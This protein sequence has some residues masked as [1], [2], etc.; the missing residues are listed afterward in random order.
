MCAPCQC[1]AS[2]CSRAIYCVLCNETVCCMHHKCNSSAMHN[3]SPM[4]LWLSSSNY[5][6]DLLCRSSCSVDLTSPMLLWLS[7]SNYN[8]DL[9]CRSSCSVDLTPSIVS[10]CSDIWK[11]DAWIYADEVVVLAMCGWT[12]ARPVVLIVYTGHATGRHFNSVTAHGL[13]RQTIK[14]I[15]HHSQPHIE[16]SVYQVRAL[17]PAKPI[18]S[19]CCCHFYWN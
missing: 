1:T 8:T 7:S 14:T 6:I 12:E 17:S 19:I 2:M 3:T 5:K 10:I 15:S 18:I 13:G 11:K 4:L 9:L 16:R